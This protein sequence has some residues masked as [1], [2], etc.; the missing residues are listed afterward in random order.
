M[1]SKL[2]DQLRASPDAALA[3]L[4]NLRPDLMVPLPGDLSA[5]AARSQSRVSVARALDGL[6]QFALEILDGLRLVRADGDAASVEALLALAVG[7]R[8]TARTRCARS[9][10]CA[11]ASSC[12]ATRPSSTWSPR[13]TRSPRRTRPGWGGPPP[14]STRRSPRW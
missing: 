4:L 5:L 12:T 3:A 11:S 7:P 1:T 6:D 8:W 14:S 9:V 13:S 2:A 10:R